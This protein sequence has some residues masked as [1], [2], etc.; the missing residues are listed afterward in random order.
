MSEPTQS[1]VSLT[2]PST[3]ESVGRCEQE[4]EQFAQQAGFNE[5][6]IQ[7]IAMAV[8]ECAV[9]AV[10]HGNQYGPDKQVQFSIEMRGPDMRVVIAD[11]GAG[12]D[13]DNLPDPLA[14]ENILRGSGRG[15]FLTRAFMDEVHFRKLDPGTEITL[16]KRLP[17]P[18][19]PAA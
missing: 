2:L 7:N 18:P 8:R 11:Q 15:I 6:D 12:F 1:R 16:S 5:D 13:P 14:P 17:E 3:L 19:S 9:N 10:M 4:A